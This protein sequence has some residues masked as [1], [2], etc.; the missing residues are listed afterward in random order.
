MKIFGLWEELERLIFRSNS[1]K[2]TVLPNSQ[3]TGDSVIQIPNMA[4][5]TQEVVLSSQPQSLSQKILVN[6]T[7]SGGALGDVTL[8]LNDSDSGFALAVQSTSTLTTNRSLTLDVEDADRTIRL[9]GDLIKSGPGNLTFTTTGTTS[10]ALPTTGT[11]STLA[12]TET[13]TGKTLNGATLNAPA[14]GGA[15]TFSLD[16]SDSA[17][18]LT[19][20]S[21]STLTAGRALT[22]DME[23]GNRTLTLAGNLTKAAAHDLTFTTI[24]STN[25]TLPT[26]GT[27]STLAGSESLSNKTVV[28]GVLS[29]TTTTSNSGTLRFNDADGSNYSGLKANATTTANI[30]YTLPAS[31][32]ASN[33]QVLSSNT[34]GETSWI[35]PLV[36]PM[37]SA[38]D[39]IYGGAGGTVTK[40]DNGTANQVLQSNGAAAPSWVSALSLAGDI[41]SSYSNAGNAEIRI[42]NL[43][44]ADM[45][46]AQFR[47]QNDAARALR[48]Q[49]TSSGQVSPKLT[50]G[51]T[52]EQGVLFTDDAYPLVFGTDTTNQGYIDAVG[53]WRVGPAAGGL[54]H[55]INGAWEFNTT[56]VSAGAGATSIRRSAA[57]TWALA[58]NGTDRLTINT[59]SVSSTLPLNPSTDNTLTLGTSALRWSAVHVGPSSFVVHGDATDTLKLTVGYNT[60]GSAAT[61]NTD[62][63][64]AQ[65][66]QIAGDTKL[67]LSTTGLFTVGATSATLVH[68]VNG[69]WQFNTT[70]AAPVEGIHRSAAGTVS[71]AA[72]S[73]DRLSVNSTTITSTLPYQ[74]P[75]GTTTNPG[76]AFSGVSSNTGMHSSG[77]DAIDWVNNGTVTG[78]ITST[79]VWTLGAVSSTSTHGINGGLNFNTTAAAAPTE[80]IFRSAAGT[81]SLAAGGAARL[82]V[83]STAVTTS[84]DNSITAAAGATNLG[85]TVNNTTDLNG[86]SSQLRLQNGNNNS[87]RMQSV[88]ASTV[89]KLGNTS[90][91]GEAGVIFTDASIPI[92]FGTN[93]TYRG[94]VSASGVWTWGG[95]SSTVTHV[96]NGGLNFNTTAAAASTNGMYRSGTSTVAISTN[97]TSRLAVDTISITSTLPHYAPDGTVSAPAYAFTNDTDLG[98]FRDGNNEY[99]IAES[100]IKVIG[101]R[102]VSTSFG[103][104]SSVPVAKWGR[105]GGGFTIA[106]GAAQ[107]FTLPST[108][109]SGLLRLVN[110]SDNTFGQIAFFANSTVAVVSGTAFT[111][112]SGSQTLVAYNAGTGVVTLS[113]QMAS[114]KNYRVTAEILDY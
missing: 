35:S 71:I 66:W 87:L 36:N 23:D 97:S 38:G 112:V 86:A 108:G 93:S 9:A 55:L 15:T 22:L 91:D 70:T 14:I 83:T 88:P 69:G 96:M 11:L 40:L 47:A 79:G 58:T 46:S 45:S 13:L 27:L 85:L 48:M 1:R 102:Q 29:G 78:G 92:L 25:V 17:F 53:R 28:S 61:Y 26:S 90:A 62:A 57:D 18:N 52:G 80:G 101:L 51:I 111:V 32:P 65:T 98:A 34:A 113:N 3:T 68:E 114:P 5:T 99:A 50:G 30:D 67:L 63:A 6:P 75:A 2:V 21:T 54:S 41:S 37:D 44:V 105:S 16:D 76:Y 60:V 43:S 39:M 20:Q 31:G 82:N 100:G 81:T 12:G 56:E 110:S 109:V 94:D 107:T 104:N 4:G 7:V 72:G 106:N 59:A 24:G 64:S 42:I 84:V 10:V 74:A 103:G 77:T 73:S 8:S 33:G 19:L 49:Y 89:D 95:V